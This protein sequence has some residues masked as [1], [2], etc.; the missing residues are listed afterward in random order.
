MR[1]R[2]LKN[3]E[4]YARATYNSRGTANRLG[5]CNARAV[6]VSRPRIS[7]LKN[8][9]APNIFPSIIVFVRFSRA[10]TY[11]GDFFFRRLSVAWKV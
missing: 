4:K 9:G 10:A 7:F 5:V 8:R 6:A 1:D 3:N 11:N 2:L